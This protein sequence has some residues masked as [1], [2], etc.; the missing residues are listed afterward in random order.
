MSSYF[1]QCFFFCSSIFYSSSSFAI[2][3]TLL[4]ASGMNISS[5]SF[6]SNKGYSLSDSMSSKYLRKLKK[7]AL[8]SERTRV[9]L[10]RAWETAAPSKDQ[11]WREFVRNT[12]VASFSPLL[13]SCKAIQS[14]HTE[15][16]LIFV[17]DFYERNQTVC[18]FV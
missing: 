14:L 3:L 8:F 11:F 10:S 6:I 16:N 15:A 9:Q 13:V 17:V 12:C 1:S 18:D 7:R 4:F 2:F 5:S